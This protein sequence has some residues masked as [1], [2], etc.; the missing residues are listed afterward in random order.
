MELPKQQDECKVCLPD[1]DIEHVR[2]YQLTWVE[3]RK[4]Y[5]RF[6]GTC[7]ACGYHGI[8]YASTAQYVFG[9]Y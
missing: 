1:F 2:K 8:K 9:D 5:P 3:V 4:K 6:N 7:K